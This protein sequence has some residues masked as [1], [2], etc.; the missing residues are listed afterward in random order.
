MW[1]SVNLSVHLKKTFWHLEVIFT[2]CSFDV[3]R[4][5]RLP[6]C[7]VCFWYVALP[8]MW[9][10]CGSHFWMGWMLNI[11]NHQPV[12]TQNG[13]PG[14]QGISTCQKF[15]SHTPEAVLLPHGRGTKTKQFP[16]QILSLLQAT[17]FLRNVS[18]IEIKSSECVWKAGFTW[19]NLQRKSFAIVV[20]ILS[21]W[22]CAPSF[23]ETESPRFSEW[24]VRLST[25]LML[26]HCL[27]FVPK[28]QRFASDASVCDH[29][30]GLQHQKKCRWNVK[31]VAISECSQEFN[32]VTGCRTT[33]KRKNEMI[34]KKM[35]QHKQE[36]S[37]NSKKASFCNYKSSI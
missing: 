29:G 17:A 23:L 27:M 21:M 33:K 28:R 34:R 3:V 24:Q 26:F 22:Q 7:W 5:P 32:A 25:R 36:I 9:L 19:C 30:V 1:N 13:T 14:N 6:V 31:K 16:T 10:Q 18:R 2:F 35:M 4:F 37:I 8:S 15:T 12:G 11:W 20:L